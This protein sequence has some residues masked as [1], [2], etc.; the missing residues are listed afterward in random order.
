MLETISHGFLGLIY[1]LFFAAWLVERKGLFKGDSSW[2]A[3]LR[4]ATLYIGWIGGL[5]V[6]LCWNPIWDFIRPDWWGK[7]ITRGDALMMFGMGVVFSYFLT[8]EVQALKKKI[9]RDP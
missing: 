5:V 2:S 7:P 3:F 1:G 4:K 8:K 6:G 9:D